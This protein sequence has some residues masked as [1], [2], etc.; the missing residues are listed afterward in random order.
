MLASHP[1]DSVPLKVLPH[2]AFHVS[3]TRDVTAN[4]Y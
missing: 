3:L 4:V 2:P 1:S